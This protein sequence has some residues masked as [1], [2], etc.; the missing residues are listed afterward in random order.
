MAFTAFLENQC[1]YFL[2]K[3]MFRK[4]SV[5]MVSAYIAGLYAMQRRLGRAMDT[6]TLQRH[7]DHLHNPHTLFTVCS[8]LAMQCMDDVDCSAICRDI[9][10]LVQLRRQDAAWDGCRKKLHDLVENDVGDFF[11]KQR[12]PAMCD[13][14][15]SCSLETDEIEAQKNNIRYAIQV[16]DDFFGG[17]AHINTIVSWYPLSSDKFCLLL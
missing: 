13:S 17:K 3:H 16:L 14:Q 5:P 10:T 12:I 11:S 4:A 7:I 15:A 9:T 1:L 2:G 6:E 8:I